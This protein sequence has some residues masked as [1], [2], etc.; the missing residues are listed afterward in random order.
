MDTDRLTIGCALLSLTRDHAAGARR[1]IVLFLAVAMPAAFDPGAEDV[2]HVLRFSLL[3]VAAVLLLGLWALEALLLG[4]RPLWRTGLHWPALALLTWLAV[5]TA[6]SEDRRTAIFGQY[7]EYDGLLS[8]A[9]VTVVLFA[10]AQAFAGGRALILLRAMYFGGGGLAAIYGLV[11][12]HDRCFPAARWDPV[13]WTS[14]NLSQAALWSTLGNPNHLAALF[15]MLLPLGLALLLFERRRSV[16]VLIVLLT[17]VMLLEMIHAQSRGAF[18]AL[19]AGLAVAGGLLW[20]DLRARPKPALVAVGLLVAA[21]FVM[22]LAFGTPACPGTAIDL[23]ERFRSVTDVEGRTPTSERIELWRAAALM[24]V[25]SP[26]FGL[27]PASYRWYLGAYQSERLANMDADIDFIDAPHSTFLHRA[28]SGGVPAVAAFVS[29]LAAAALLV[30]AA[31][32]RLPSAQIS[33]VGRGSRV[34]LAGAASG[35]TAFVVQAT[36]NVEHLGLSVPFWIFLGLVAA[37]ATDAENLPDRSRPAAPAKPKRRGKRAPAPRSVAVWRS[38]VA[39]AALTAAAWA[40]VA[41]TGPYRADRVYHEALAAQRVIP[42]AGP[43]RASA[44]S[45][46]HGGFMDAIAIHP[47]EPAYRANYAAF[48]VT[49][50]GSFTTAERSLVIAALQEAE[51]LLEEAIDQQPRN[52]LWVGSLA[53]VLLKLNELDPDETVRSEGV[54]AV[55]RALDLNPWRQRPAVTLA[56]SLTISGDGSADEPGLVERALSFSPRDVELLRAAARLYESR[57]DQPRARELW[58]RLLA[59]VPDDAEARQATTSR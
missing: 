33:D 39:I 47:L 51:R 40:A 42:Q 31:I 43:S 12:L 27:G 37:V 20:P 23:P 49:T 32:R 17:A 22:P 38:G 14:E 18:L 26:I 28:T 41:S 25:D 15:A 8:A 48:V 4:Q 7:R 36:F 30:A 24:T 19:A 52:H 44:I 5:A 29:V 59:L 34:A 35:A 6:V 57:E 45:R 1:A 55:R 53:D 54:S 2:F 50:P 56:R 58:L 11:Q 21:L 10:T 13:N 9:G 3:L 46:A 16:Q